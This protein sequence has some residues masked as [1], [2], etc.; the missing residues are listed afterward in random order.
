LV[1]TRLKWRHG[2]YCCPLSYRYGDFYP[3]TALGRLTAC[4]ASYVGIL[5]IAL[6]VTIV[7]THFT[8]EYDRLYGRDRNRG[9][10][11]PELEREDSSTTDDGSVPPAGGLTLGPIPEGNGTEMVP[12]QSP[13][14]NPMISL[15]FIKTPKSGE[16]PSAPSKFEQGLHDSQVENLE[17]ILGELSRL[18]QAISIIRTRLV[19][20][21]GPEEDEQEKPGG[22]VGGV[23]EATELERPQERQE[24]P[25]VNSSAWVREAETFEL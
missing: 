20:V 22:I 5:C 19:S 2:S 21:M 23:V 9:A 13:A 25:G 6:P 11:S 3:T 18:E 1:L 17:G 10:G 4:V 24:E 8:N 12:I 16:T 7:G 15:T 14:G